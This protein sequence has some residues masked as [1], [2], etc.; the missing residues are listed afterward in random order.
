MSFTGNRARWL[1][2]ALQ[3][4]SSPVPEERSMC[5]HRRVG[6]FACATLLLSIATFLFSFPLVAQYSTRPEQQEIPSALQPPVDEKLILQLHAKGD[7]IYSCKSESGQFYWTLKAPDARLFDSKEQPFGKHFAGPTWQSS[8]G[9]RV[10]GKLAATV[11]SPDA[12]SI[13]WLLLKVVS[14][15]GDGILSH[16]TTIQRLHTQGGKAP[17][18]GCDSDHVNQE[19]RVPYSADYVFY[20]PK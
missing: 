19:K 9:S 15:T 10:T 17:S 12:D 13:P 16:A 2:L 6:K 8:D 7:Q 20:A 3:L 1:W 4:K 11:D 14:H 5:N 18:D